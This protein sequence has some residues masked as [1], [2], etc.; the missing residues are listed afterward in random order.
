MLSRW[1]P[2]WLKTKC[3]SFALGI[4]NWS[5]TSSPSMDE[6]KVKAWTVHSGS[7]NAH[8]YALLTQRIESFQVQ[9]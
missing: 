9:E 2:C 5:W 1:L 3:G 6:Q 8:M 7:Y 4:T